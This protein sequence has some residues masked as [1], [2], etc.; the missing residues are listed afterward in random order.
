VI[1]Y[2]EAPIQD[3]KREWLPRSQLGG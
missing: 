3:A 2:A 1:Q